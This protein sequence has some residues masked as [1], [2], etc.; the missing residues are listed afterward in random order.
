[1]NRHVAAAIS[2]TIPE[3]AMEMFVTKPMAHRLSQFLNK[4]LLRRMNDLN[5]PIVA[6]YGGHTEAEAAVRT[7][8]R[9]GVPIKDISI[10]GRDF[11]IREDAQ[12]FYRPAD[13]AVEGATQGAWFGGLFGLMAGAFGFF[14]FPLVG[15]LFVFGPL[16]GLVAGMIGGAGVGALI[17][18]L[19][20]AGVPLDLAVK[21]QDHVQAGKF[22]VVVHGSADMVAAAKRTLASTNQ[23]IA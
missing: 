7:L 18:A 10:L 17:N 9:S 8:A 15:P 22:I 19:V 14:V 2:Q 20:A 21:Y 4:E 16:A 23:E 11:E 3:I 13:A 6:V 12:G 5:E 1:L